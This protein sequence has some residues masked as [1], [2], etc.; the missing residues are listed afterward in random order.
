MNVNGKHYR[1]IWINPEDKNSIQIIDQRHLPH[2]FIIETLRNTEEV[3]KA[4]KEMHVRGAG[5]IGA[6]AGY[7]MHLASLEASENNFNS[8]M[9]QAGEKLKSTRPTAINLAWAIDKQLKNLKEN[10]SSRK[11]FF[12]TAQQIAEEDAENCKTIGKNG[13]EVIENIYKIKKGIV[14]ILTHCNAGWLAFVDYGSA[15]SPIYVAHEKGIPVHVWVDMTAPWNQGGK[16]TSWEL[17]Q[18]GVPYTII[19]DNEGGKLMQD[20]MIDLVF[21]GADRITRNGDVANKIGT[22]LKA[23]SAKDNNISFYVAA[24]LSTFDLKISDGKDIPIEERSPEEVKYASGLTDKGVIEKILLTPKNSNA[25]NHGFDIT[26]ARLITGII[27]ERG[28]CM[29]NKKSI[30]DVFNNP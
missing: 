22:Y 15:L 11:I 17:E 13:L 20:K 23:L 2:E 29:P 14:N 25:L 18:Q 1:T 16:L 28:I 7:G 27:T 4:I 19:S 21:V 24:P 30:E 8:Y 26:P 10:Y 3:E 6:T 12:E 5:L 9:I